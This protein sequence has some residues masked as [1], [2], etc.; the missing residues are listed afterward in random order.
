MLS[1]SYTDYLVFWEPQVPGILQ[2]LSIPVQGLLYLYLYHHEIYGSHNR[3]K[4][5]GFLQKKN[6][7]IPYNSLSAE[8][9]QV[10]VC[11]LEL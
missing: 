3:F 2:V 7:A 6:V 10:S 4:P 9:V 8:R 5:C 11:S 1:P